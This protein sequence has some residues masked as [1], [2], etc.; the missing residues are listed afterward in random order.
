MIRGWR[1]NDRVPFVASRYDLNVVRFGNSSFALWQD[2]N[3]GDKHSCHWRIELPRP[4]SVSGLAS[5]AGD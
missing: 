3:W 5:D 1:P 4:A 2:H